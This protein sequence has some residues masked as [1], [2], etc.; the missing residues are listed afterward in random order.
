MRSLFPKKEH[1]RKEIW[2]CDI[3]QC[4]GCKDL[5]Y[6]LDNLFL[7]NHKLFV[8]IPRFHRSIKKEGRRKNF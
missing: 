8:N 1:W 2:V 4:L 3:F 7:G 5:G 6:K